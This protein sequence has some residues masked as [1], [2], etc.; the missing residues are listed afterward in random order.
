MSV[1]KWKTQSATY[2]CSNTWKKSFYSGFHCNLIAICVTI[3]LINISDIYEYSCISR[4]LGN[5]YSFSIPAPD[6]TVVFASGQDS[7]WWR[8][9]FFEKRL[10]ACCRVQQLSRSLAVIRGDAHRAPRWRRRQQTLCVEWAAEHSTGPPPGGPL[11]M[12]TQ[13]HL[14]FPCVAFVRE[15]VKLH[16]SKPKTLQVST[17]RAVLLSPLHIITACILGLLGGF[18]S[19][20]RQPFIILASA[21]TSFA[22][23]S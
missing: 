17:W 23:L 1:H 12:Q 7:S 15:V 2:P 16:K 10:V 21:S 18:S 11:Q 14:T 6:I 19:H 4:L 20:Q 9:C 5:L 22:A 3:R 8:S 13:T